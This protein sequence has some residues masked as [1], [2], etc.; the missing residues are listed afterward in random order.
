MD[1]AEPNSTST[2]AQQL[3]RFHASLD[4]ATADP[5]FLDRFYDS[6]MAISPEIASIFEHSDMARLKRKLKSSL[7]IMTLA[8]DEAP[9]ADEYLRFLGRTHR[10]F[11]IAPSHFDLWTLSLVATAR[12]CDPEFDSELDSIWSEVIRTGV[13]IM[14]SALEATARAGDARRTGR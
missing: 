13:D 3:E 9:G 8:V 4:R 1:G 11:E 14:R 10:R 6:F 2:R 5:A 7:H 12:R